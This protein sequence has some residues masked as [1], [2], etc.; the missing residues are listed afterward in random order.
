MAAGTPPPAGA[1]A[2]MSGFMAH[3]R[4]N[5]FA[6]G[7][8]E[9]E[10]VLSTLAAN[11]F[12]NADAARLGLKT[13]LSG[14]REQWA[15]FD[16]LFDAY[17]FE[18]GLRTVERLGQSTATRSHRPR[19]DIWDKVLPADEQAEA[20]GRTDRAPGIGQGD[21]EKTSGR[22]VASAGDA[23]MRTD[24]RTLVTPDEMAEAERTAERLA[25][26]IRYRLSRRRLPSRR[27]EIIDLRR[28][29]RRSIS[30]GG[31]PVELRRKHRPERP[32]KLVVLLDVSG[33]MK[34]YS[35]YFLSFVRG[36]IG[37]WLRADAFLFHTRLVRV[38]DVLRESDANIA[39]AK[40]SLLVEGFGGGTRI[41]TSLK[42]F[43]DRYAKETLGSRSVAIVISD[44]YDT[45]PPEALAVELQ[46]VKRRAYRLIWL[47]PLL[48]WKDYAPVA[49]AMAVALQYVDCFAPA[50][51][52]ESLAALED[53]FARL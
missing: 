15:R 29:I 23:L 33:S 16:D 1:A 49:R 3:L 18:R 37:T 46:R 2:R 13:M 11:E 25:R 26:A 17:W 9:T 8:G 51:S 30:H 42:A 39:M 24:L 44:G 45:D 40:L 43:N 19:P 34:V 32:V 38:A 53:E 48:G 14:S 35:R 12:P 50:H 7:P 10:L 36:L 27:G 52:L 41:A 47:N 6:V 22:L 21:G 5:G 4:R 31:E 28:T 20:Q